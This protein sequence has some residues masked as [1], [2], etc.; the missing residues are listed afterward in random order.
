[1]Y[2]VNILMKSESVIVSDSAV[3]VEVQ[4]AAESK[5]LRWFELIL[6]LTVAFGI[7]S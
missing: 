5:L 7:S 2:F 4:T 1:M 6:V 3:E